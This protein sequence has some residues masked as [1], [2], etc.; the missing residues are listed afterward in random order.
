MNF[1]NNI[2]SNDMNQQEEQRPF[3][4]RHQ[5]RMAP[6]Q[7]QSSA[8]FSPLSFGEQSFQPPMTTNLALIQVPAQAFF[9]LSE[10]TNACESMLRTVQE[11]LYTMQGTLQ[12]VQETLHRI[13]SKGEAD[14]IGRQDSLGKMSAAHLEPS[15]PALREEDIPAA[16]FDR[17]RNAEGKVKSA[18]RA[19]VK[20]ALMTLY[21]SEKEANAA[22]KGL[23]KSVDMCLTWIKRRLPKNEQYQSWRSL[24]EGDRDAV[25]GRFVD[26]VRTALQLPIDKC[27]KNWMARCLL[28]GTFDNIRDQAARKRIHAQAVYDDSRTSSAAPV[29]TAQRSD[30]SIL[31]T[32]DDAMSTTSYASSVISA[33]K[34]AAS[35]A[36]R[37]V[38]L[39][40]RIL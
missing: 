9:D 32:A 17:P 7:Q 28:I 25:M 29:L 24:S 27:E 8:G 18:T 34:R 14:R 19:D 5:Q 22:M 11:A 39:P 33:G 12:A 16:F 4:V 26:G 3:A 15:T 1:D 6:F 2:N 31:T 20:N 37:F 13:E 38:L 36:S 23:D 35:K 30:M 10:R 40:L 21:Q